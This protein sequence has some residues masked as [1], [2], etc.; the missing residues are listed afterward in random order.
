MGD[1]APKRAFT[2]GP[3]NVN[4]DPLMIARAIREGVDAR[5]VDSDRAAKL[6]AIPAG[7]SPADRRVQSLL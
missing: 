1:R 3:L 5:L 7:A 4:V 6:A 2:L